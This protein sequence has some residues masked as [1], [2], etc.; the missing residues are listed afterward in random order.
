MHIPD[1]IRLYWS[2]NNLV[3]LT[4]D[5]SGT[6]LL[7]SADRYSYFQ[8]TSVKCCFMATFAKQTWELRLVII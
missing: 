8:L 7:S 1:G 5:M 6:V 2:N 4:L 3:I